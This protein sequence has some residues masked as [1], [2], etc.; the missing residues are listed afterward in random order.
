MIN[1]NIIYVCFWRKASLSGVFSKETHNPGIG[2]TDFTSIRLA[3]FLAEYLPDKQV[4]LVTNNAG[5]SIESEKKNLSLISVGSIN[6]F[7]EEYV[8]GNAGIVLISP[9]YT[10][11]QVK[12]NYLY[13]SRSNIIAWSRHPYD[14]GYPL[15]DI[16]F[17]AC[18]CVGEYQFYSNKSLSSPLWF[19][20]HLFL[21]PP[22]INRN[23]VFPEN[24]QNE[25]RIVYLGALVKAKGFHFIAEQWRKIKS[26]YPNVRLHV[27]GSAETYGFHMDLHELIPTHKDYAEQILASVDCQ[28]ILDGRVV[29]HGNLGDEKFDIIK[30]SHIGIIN[31]TGN[32]ESFCT[33]AVEILSCGI[34]LVS[35]RDFGMYETMKYFPELSLKRPEDIVGKIQYVLGDRDRYNE[36]CSR[37]LFVGKY[38][39]SQN[40]VIMAR[41]VR[42]INQVTNKNVEGS[43]SPLGRLE[44]G[45]YYVNYIN[46]RIWL[47]RFFPGYKYLRFIKRTFIKLFRNGWS[48]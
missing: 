29:F 42:L 22:Q 19:I 31:P 28:D 27:I 40:S 4:F 32:S 30:N 7:F 18:V 17:A 39:D 23:I 36:L 37:S 41:W 14:T 13:E 8:I 45:S 12:R 3:F 46:L 34:P 33:S 1:N 16:K 26:I 5:F 47:S 35:S 11:A 20:P 48:L 25:L 6:E 10:L 24:K 2:G 44:Y 21:L 9:K 43:V 38:F 15:S